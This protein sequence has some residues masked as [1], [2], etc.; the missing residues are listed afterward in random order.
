ML[1]RLLTS[2]SLLLLPYL[3]LGQAPV[4]LPAETFKQQLRNKYLHN[5]T[6]Q[7]I[8]N[9]YSKRQAGGAG[10]IVGGALSAARLAV[11]GGRTTTSNGIVVEQQ[12]ANIGAVLLV[13]APFLGYGLGKM[14][15]YSNAH[16]EQQLTAYAAGQPLPR[17]LRRKLKPRFFDQVIINYKPV[18]VAPAP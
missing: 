6:A 11:G 8:V 14:L 3:S 1:L 4:N 12:S 18:P 9:L 7:A 2:G 17:S 15:H 5:D 10:W 13:T 16:L